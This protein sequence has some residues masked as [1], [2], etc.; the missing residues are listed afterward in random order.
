[1]TKILKFPAGFF[2]G[3]STSAHQIEG[4][5][6]NDWSEWEKCQLRI[7]N[8]KSRG[9][10]PDDYISG[11]ACNS[12]E[13]FDKD[14][15]CIKNLNLN[16]YRF[17]VDWSRIEPEK[18]SINQD[19]IRYYQEILKELKIN[20]IEPFVTLW[21]WPL[22]LWLSRQ[23][24]WENK[25]TIKHFLDFTKIFLENFGSEIKYWIPL[26]E[27]SIYSLNSYLRGLWPPQKKNIFKYF[28]VTK[29][30]TEAHKQAYKL[31]KKNLPQ[32]QIGIAHNM[33]HFE[34][35]LQRGVNVLLKKIFDKHWNFSLLEKIEN[36]LDFIGLNFYFHN[37]INFGLNKNE[38]KKISDLNWELYPESIY[39][40]LKDL[41]NYNKPIYITEN[42]LADE[43]DKNRV[44]YI[45]G[46]LENI[47][48][49]ISEGVDVRGYFHWSLLDNFEWAHGFSQKFGLYAVDRKTFA[50]T[51]RPSADYYAEICKDNQVMIN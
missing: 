42:G 40:I 21:H 20:N 44:W 5:L 2:W 27:P 22:P 41:K 32:A 8:L 36:E 39:H 1:M 4:G 16:A 50:R 17:S 25:K 13:C 12:Y 18:G 46:V 9:L 26:N 10:N 34:A 33:S 47:H 28:A 11:Q 49:A 23:G 51:A 30:L 35:H 31:I 6:N 15:E 14:L 43:A 45:K 7:A 48:R 19:G 3:A 24:G 38:N 37:R 29:N